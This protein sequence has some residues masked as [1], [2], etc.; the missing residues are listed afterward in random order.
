MSLKG[1]VNKLSRKENFWT[2]CHKRPK[3]QMIKT[4]KQNFL[5]IDS[6]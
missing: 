1:T 6:I 2:F 5:R 3:V 4:S